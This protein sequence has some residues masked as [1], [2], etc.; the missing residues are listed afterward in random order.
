[1][2]EENQRYGKL[3]VIGI[4]AIKTGQQKYIVQCDCGNIKSVVGGSLR[5][6][7]TLSCGCLRDETARKLG[8]EKIGDK[9]PMFGK[10]GEK[11]PNYGRKGYFLGKRGSEA[12]NYKGGKRKQSRLERET[13]EYQEW[14]K[15]VFARDNY[16]CRKCNQNSHKLRAHHLYSFIS[17]IELRTNI[18]NGVTLCD[19]CHRQFHKEY[20]L[21]NNTAEQFERWLEDSQRIG[22]EN[23]GI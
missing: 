10:I 6:G 4:D 3:I 11:C 16:L 12:S 22:A 7:K 1:M 8:K 21:L 15:Q 5:D 23:Y 17:N 18:D 19:N 2:I 20:G 9:N 13:P 14:R